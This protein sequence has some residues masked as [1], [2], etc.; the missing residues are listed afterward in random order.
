MSIY[1]LFLMAKIFDCGLSF[2]EGKDDQQMPRRKCV[3]SCARVTPQ[4]SSVVKVSVHFQNLTAIRSRSLFRDPSRRGSFA[5]DVIILVQYLP[6]VQPYVFH[7]VQWNKK[8]S[9]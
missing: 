7:T 3:R 5:A 2:G 9:G 8:L 1:A 4:R 6:P